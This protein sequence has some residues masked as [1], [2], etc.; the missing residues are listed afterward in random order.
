MSLYLAELELV[1]WKCFR[2]E[3][4]VRFGRGLHAVTARQEDNAAR[5]NWLGKTSLLS[6]IR[7]AL[8]G[9]HGERL[10]DMWISR[11]RGGSWE[12][13][14]A[15]VLARLS[16]GTVITRTRR[17]GKSTQ[18]GVLV[19]GSG[20]AL[21]SGPDAELK[22]AHLLGLSTEEFDDVCFFGQKQLARRLKQDPA[23]RM[24]TFAKWFGL[25][26]L[27]RCWEHDSAELR[28]LQTEHA[29]MHAEFVAEQA[30]LESLEKVV[31]A[32]DSDPDVLREQAEREK[33]AGRA[34]NE[35]SQARAAL[36]RDRLDSLE[37]ER[38]KAEGV[39]ATAALKALRASSP[40]QESAL[41]DQQAAEARA[42]HQNADLEATK[43]EKL[44]RGE[45]DGVCPLARLA[46]PSAPWV[47]EVGKR[48]HEQLQRARGALETAARRRVELDG[49]QREA[50]LAAQE[51]ASREATLVQL[52]K[53]AEALLPAHKRHQAADPKADETWQDAA[54]HFQAAAELES[55]ANALL[56]ARQGLAKARGQARGTQAR[57]GEISARM[58]V[59]RES[60]L[61]FGRAGA[62][63][64]VAERELAEIERSGCTAL[65][66]LGSG[67]SYAVT[68]GRPVQGQLAPH[69]DAC[70]SPFAEKKATRCAC[71]AERG[72][73]LNERLDI[74]PNR[75]SGGAED[76]CGLA[77]GL[78]SWAWLRRE[79][80]S[81]WGAVFLDEPFGALD[82]HHKRELSVQLPALLAAVGV[83]QAFLVAHEAA[84][85]DAAAARVSIV[86]DGEWSRIEEV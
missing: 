20:P 61:V 36:E 42:A 43:A 80:A 3:H 2:G 33:A 68:W 53:R 73:K 17:R 71:G 9:E 57:L 48:D 59:L 7:F 19:P 50:R 12:A 44:A 11:E 6:A 51:V 78:A 45:F 58:A 54:V 25:G 86:S 66:S 84:L 15:S 52:R 77:F 38:L 64:R 18:V 79:R 41:V 32:L 28:R 24:A 30:R 22:I 72:P 13:D 67:L 82:L 56:A 34:A 16:D 60:C 14:G 55:R 63:R 49:K 35:A 8:T 83:E 26:P 74:V 21:A 69:C 1:N 29:V 31:E 76:L 5:S 46:C 65:A 10:E 81:E 27:Q 4:K 70:G 62:Q 75:V 47:T 40:E 37:F 39:A 23:E 85:V